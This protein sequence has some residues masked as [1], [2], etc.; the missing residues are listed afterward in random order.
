VQQAEGKAQGGHKKGGAGIIIQKSTQSWGTEAEDAITLCSERNIKGIGIRE[1]QK[2]AP[3]GNLRKKKQ[4]E[5]TGSKK[6]PTGTK[7]GTNIK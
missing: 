1:R 5:L 6:R 2:I 3:N 4:S 7:S